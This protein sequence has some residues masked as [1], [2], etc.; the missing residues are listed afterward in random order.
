MGQA[1]SDACRE[2]CESL[3]RQ[4][5][6][7]A[8]TDEHLLDQLILPASLAQGTSRLLAAEPS[9][10]AQTALHIA[11]MLVPGVRVSER[12]QGDL[13]LIEIEGVGHRPAVSSTPRTLDVTE[14]AEDRRRAKDVQR[15]ADRHIRELLCLKNTDNGIASLR[16]A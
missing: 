9:L 13:T 1:Y 10:H 14:E 5:A 16:A 2:A 4:L 15:S 11:K 6:S 7:G 8:A 12:R 3:G